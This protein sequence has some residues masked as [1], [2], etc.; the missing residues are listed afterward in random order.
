MQPTESA[1]TLDSG[2]YLL[3][4]PGAA[5]LLR[6]PTR[7]AQAYVGTGNQAGF[8][9]EEVGDGITMQAVLSEYLVVC[10]KSWG[11][12]QEGGRLPLI[13]WERV[14]LEDFVEVGRRALEFH[15]SFRELLA[16]L[17]TG[18]REREREQGK[19]EGGQGAA[20]SP[21]PPG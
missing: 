14:P 9:E 19:V 10:P 8:V 16:R 17:R 13:D 18:A 4:R 7:I 6:I 21:A 11:V 2:S 1:F 20:P 15:D 3:R 5:G 12:A